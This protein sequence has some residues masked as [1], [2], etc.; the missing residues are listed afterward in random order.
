MPNG[1]SDFAGRSDPTRPPEASGVWAGSGPAARRRGA[2]LW[3]IA[4]NTLAEI[5]QRRMIW[6]AVVVGVFLVFGAVAQLVFVEKA[7]TAGETKLAERLGLSLAE[8]LAGV[9][10]FAAQMI[11]LFLGASAVSTEVR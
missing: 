2:A 9:W 5:R 3:A 11:A 4:V 10:A 8:R 7:W 1:L 6:I